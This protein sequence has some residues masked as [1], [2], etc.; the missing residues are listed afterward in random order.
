MDL[1]TVNISEA[2]LR[3]SRHKSRGW[4]DLQSRA[5]FI[6]FSLYNPESSLLL[7]AR[8][9][10]EFSEF[11]GLIKSQDFSIYQLQKYSGRDGSIALTLDIFFVVI[12]VFYLAVELIA[13]VQMK[14]RYF[15][16]RPS[17]L[18]NI[19]IALI[20]FAIIAI[21]L[22]SKNQID[23]QLNAIVSTSEETAALLAGLQNLPYL[24]QQDDNLI[25][26]LFIVIYG[27][28]LAYAGDVPGV[29]HLIS[30]IKRCIIEV[31]PLLSL[32]VINFVG[33]SLAFHVIFGLK[34]LEYRTVGSSFVSN[35]L[36][37]LG[38]T[39]LYAQ[40]YDS[41]KDMAG[42]V[43]AIF[44]VSE[45]ILL[46]NLF[47]A[48]LVHAYAMTKTELEKEPIVVFSEAIES[49]LKLLSKAGTEQR[50]QPSNVM[51]GKNEMDSS[52][53]SSG[54]NNSGERDGDVRLNASLQSK[55]ASSPLAFSSEQA[56]KTVSSRM[57]VGSQAVPTGVISSTSAMEESLLEISQG[58]ASFD[59]IK[60][61]LMAVS[62][63]LNA[64]TDFFLSQPASK[65]E[66]HV[67][68]INRK[69]DLMAEA[70]VST[71]YRGSEKN[72][73]TMNDEGESHRHTSS[74]KSPTSDRQ[75]PGLQILR[76][77]MRTLGRGSGRVPGWTE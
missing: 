18:L 51:R 45:N 24:K 47:I 72:V 56:I 20:S 32:V 67:E 73:T 71:Q 46:F 54:W 58:V 49:V 5:L 40:M 26:I 69:L 12:V 70:L 77:G 29:N 36:F 22:E 8:L 43:C 76:P 10:I 65:T 52:G 74:G 17:G 44:V 66:L 6:D 1:P 16:L 59:T 61:Q 33:F 64:L 19:L 21:R 15:L 57:I 34:M 9:L 68:L 38:E 50:V 63:K 27:R 39:S 37:L 25:A 13:L 30:T 75:T 23:S 4:L 28:L 35:A 62:E 60:I 41:N 55:G 53:L 48:I 3:I 14:G 11:G 2:K 42:F 7:R 31:I